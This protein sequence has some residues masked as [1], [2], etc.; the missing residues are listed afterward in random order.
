[1]RLVRGAR[2]HLCTRAGLVMLHRQDVKYHR[3]VLRQ[4]ARLPQNVFLSVL[5]GNNSLVSGTYHHAL[6]RCAACRMCAHARTA[7]YLS[8]KQRLPLDPYVQLVIG[9]TFVQKSEARDEDTVRPRANESLER[10][11]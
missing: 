4:A 10:S 8:A 9:V 6:G 1:M 2:V 11:G 3:Y 7:E 5:S